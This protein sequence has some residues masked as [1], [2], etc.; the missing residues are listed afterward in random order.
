MTATRGVAVAAW[1]DVGSQAFRWAVDPQGFRI[2]GD[3]LNLLRLPRLLT[4][5]E[6]LDFDAFLLAHYEPV[7][8]GLVLALGNVQRA[9]D[10]SQEAFARAFRRWRSVSVMANPVGWVYVVAM[11]QARHDLRRGEPAVNAQVEAPADVAGAVA[12]TIALETALKSLAPRQRAAVVLR[13]L[14]DLSTAQ[15]AEAMG[16]A[17]GT[18]KSTLH[19]AL[20]HLRIEMEEDQE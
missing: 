1:P 8:R 13:Y 5:V 15:V 17:E 4:V 11:N 7:R 12:T 10:V 3:S 16:C 9:E 19:A 18:V 20:A 2:R 6:V 14:A